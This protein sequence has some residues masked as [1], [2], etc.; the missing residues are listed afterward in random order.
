MIAKRAALAQIA[1]WN[2]DAQRSHPA[3]L[4]TNRDSLL[5]VP[6]PNFLGAGLHKAAG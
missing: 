2:P 1:S 4:N 3:V 5:S 6:H